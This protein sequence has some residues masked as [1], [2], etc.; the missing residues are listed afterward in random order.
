MKNG[1]RSAEGGSPEVPG[2]HSYPFRPWVRRT[3]R[4]AML[5]GAAALA[6]CAGLAWAFQ[7][8]GSAP[9][10]RAFGVLALYAIVFLL[11]LGKIWWTAGEPAVELDGEALWFRP[12]HTF[13]RRR[14]ALSAV[15][16]AGPRP[17]TQSL[18]LLV[19]RGAGDARELF[20]NL[21]VIHQVHAFSDELGRELAAAGLEPVPGRP[22]SW[23]R[24][25]WDSRDAAGAEEREPGG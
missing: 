16:A 17:G 23:A 15:V 1:S 8:P 19:A 13:G 20:L 6:L 4:R 10:S 2:G 21:G 24:P 11:S 9:L 18:R 25:G 5:W 7:S 22:A 3:C 14:V 12:L